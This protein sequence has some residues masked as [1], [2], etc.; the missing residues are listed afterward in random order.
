MY[1]VPSEKD[2]LLTQAHHPAHMK[3][4]EHTAWHNGQALP[5]DAGDVLMWQSNAIHWGSECAAG[6][7]KPRKSISTMFMRHKEGVSNCIAKADLQAGLSLEARLRIVMRALL[8]Y[9]THFPSF[10]GL[11]WTPDLS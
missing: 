4:D 5:C 9:K 7:A 1:V 2:E 10:E 6:V 8:I 3:P 11:D